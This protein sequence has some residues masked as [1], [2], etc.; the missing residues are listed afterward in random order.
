MKPQPGFEHILRV[1]IPEAV[2]DAR[3]AEILDYCRRT[4]CRTVS[5]FSSS[6]DDEP[7]FK[8]PAAIRRQVETVLKPAAGFLRRHRIGVI[9][10]VM[11]TSGH[12]YFPAELHREFPFQPRIT[13]EGATDSG[14]ACLL[15]PALRQWLAESYRIYAEIEADAILVDDDFRTLLRDGLTCFCPEHLRRIAELAGRSA[16]RQE[17]RDAI[18]ADAWPPHPLREAYFQVTTAGFAATAA[19]IRDA[20]KTVAPATRLGVMTAVWPRG[21]AGIDWEIVLRALCGDERPLVR[22]QI[23]IYQEVGLRQFVPALLAP[24]RFRAVL[25]PA[26][27]CWPEIENYPAADGYAKSATMTLAQIATTIL[28]GFRQPMGNFFDAFGRSFADYEPLIAQLERKRPLLDTLCRM[29]PE[30][31]RPVGARIFVHRDGLKVRRSA[32]DWYGGRGLA[33]AM[34]LLGL[35]LTHAAG[36][37]WQVLCGDDLLGCSDAELDALLR[38]GAV[39]DVTA[40]EALALRGLAGRVGVRSGA[41]LSSDEIGYEEFLPRPAG[42]GVSGL[43]LRGFVWPQL[44]WR[45]LETVGN[46]W[47]EIR[48][49]IRNYRKESVAPGMI[50]SENS[51]GERFAVLACDWVLPHAYRARQLREALEWTARQMLPA[52]AEPTA[53]CLWPVVNRTVDGGWILGLLNGSTD[54]LHTIPLRLSP[55]LAQLEFARLNDDGKWTAI[56]RPQSTEYTVSATLAPLEYLVLGAGI[57]SK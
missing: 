14:G 31:A 10:N 39:L 23:S 37:P 53:P 3:L 40:L 9:L 30:G 18:F 27:E 2:R 32:A 12:V 22:P 13:A 45:R 33:D 54:T 24:D 52:V 20:V 26:T 16:T 1:T 4:G 56:A 49:V 29:I 25:P 15:D 42:G 7:S 28:Q 55:E 11:Q 38:Q 57:E 48:S 5:L 8:S 35:P 21:A 36:M 44:C 6:Y 50:W 19:L 51:A 17:V 46:G 47:H 43:P 41:A 34:S